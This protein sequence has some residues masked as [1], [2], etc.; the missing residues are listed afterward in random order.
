MTGTAHH[1][2]LLEGL[3]MCPPDTFASRIQQGST[4]LTTGA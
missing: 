1:S 2:S 4:R 3:E